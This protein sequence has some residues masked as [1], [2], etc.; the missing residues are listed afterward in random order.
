MAAACEQAAALLEPRVQL[1]KLNTEEVP[2]P[3]AR[4][5]IRS[6][7]TMVL[8]RGGKEVARQSGAMG[9]AD[10]VRCVQKNTR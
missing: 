1:G 4:F 7:P 9:N 3:S 10:I 6:I 5:S 2:E 8:F